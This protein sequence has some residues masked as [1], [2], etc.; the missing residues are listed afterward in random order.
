MVA[1]DRRSAIEFQLAS[2][3]PL[4]HRLLYVVLLSTFVGLGAWVVLIT[5]YPASAVAPYTLGVPPVGILASFIAN[6]ER[7]TALEI[8]GSAVVLAGLVAIVWPRRSPIASNPS[9]P[10]AKVERTTQPA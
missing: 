7:M 6:G 8:L 4:E 9:V 3:L 1:D 5:Q 10:A 2:P